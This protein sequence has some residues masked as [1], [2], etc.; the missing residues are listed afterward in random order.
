MA[1]PVAWMPA[2]TSFLA[3]ARPQVRGE[4]VAAGVQSQMLKEL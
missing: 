4:R 1:S 2:A 3:L